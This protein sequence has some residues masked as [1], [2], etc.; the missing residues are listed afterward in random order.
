MG[1]SQSCVVIAFTILKHMLFD[2]NGPH[3]YQ[4]YSH[5]ST[6]TLRWDLVLLLPHLYL[7]WVGGKDDIREMSN[8]YPPAGEWTDITPQ[9]LV[10][11]IFDKAKEQAW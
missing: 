9:P 10:K 2:V 3:V 11:V 1:G 8:K 6:G 4:I 7:K 5:G